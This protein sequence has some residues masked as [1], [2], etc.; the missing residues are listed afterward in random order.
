[1]PLHPPCFHR[2]KHQSKVTSPSRTACFLVLNT[3]VLVGTFCMFGK[4][5]EKVNFND[6]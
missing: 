6:L 4:K 1:M 2:T 3:P 5:R